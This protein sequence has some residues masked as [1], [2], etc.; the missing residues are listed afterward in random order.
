MITY[1]GLGYYGLLIGLGGAALLRLLP[2][3][4]RAHRLVSRA[5]LAALLVTAALVGFSY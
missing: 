2:R 3:E 5:L 4:S 1:H